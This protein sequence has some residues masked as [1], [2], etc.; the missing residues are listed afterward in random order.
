[1]TRHFDV[2]QTLEAWLAEGPSL[3]PDHVIDRIV[4]QLDK[5]EQRRPTWLPG[6]ERMNRMMVAIVG[7]AAA[8]AL[9]VLAAGLYLGRS[10][11]APGVGGPPA[12]TASPTPGPT[13]GPTELQG[14]LY[15]S[16][17]H[18]YSLLL[19]DDTWTVEELPGSWPLGDTF[20]QEGP[21]ADSVSKEASE[22]GP[23]ILFNSQPV[24]TGT[25]L[26]QWVTDYDE[27]GR[28]WFPTCQVERSDTG[29]VGGET[30]RINSYRC[31]GTDRAREAV[32]LHGGRAYVIRVFGPEGDP[33]FDP[34]PILDEW[35]SRFQF[36]D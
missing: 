6:R 15:T 24:P 28:I 33:S 7:V 26:Q 9:A 35:V 17:R 30:A 10:S 18:G 27:A 14:V 36:T 16:E 19:P 12:P 4:R 21:G 29:V 22:P 1:M 23:F 8:V 5:T 34:R 2:D 32:T 20:N 3:L 13:A 25:T 11:N 31:T